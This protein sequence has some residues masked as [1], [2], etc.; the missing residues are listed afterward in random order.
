ME[1]Q[2]SSGSKVG[3]ST[4]LGKLSSIFG[5][6]MAAFFGLMMIVGIFSAVPDRAGMIVTALFGI[7]IG[8]SFIVHGWRAKGQISRFKKYVSILSGQNETNIDNIAAA[9]SQSVDF[10]KNDLQ[11]MMNK[12]FFVDAYI[13]EAANEIVL[14]KKE[15]SVV[16]NA[17]AVGG[18]GAETVA[19]A[20][21]G[22]GANN[23]VVKGSVTECEFCGS[24][25]SA[26]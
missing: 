19:V 18:D 14:V 1:N 10:V 6:C 24:P 21:K 3:L 5:Y 26:G 4:F 11:K 7:A 22:C 25:V 17:N 2:H 16:Y 20:C 15:N 8:V 9:T 13:D 12:K 23:R